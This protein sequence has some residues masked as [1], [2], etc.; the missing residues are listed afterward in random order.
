MDC[1]FEKPA[2]CAPLL[3]DV[4]RCLPIWIQR[5]RLTKQT[6]HRQPGHETSNRDQRPNHGR[7]SNFSIT[8]SVSFFSGISPL[9]KTYR[10]MRTESPPA[11]GTPEV[12]TCRLTTREP[13]VSR[14]PATVEKVTWPGC[15][16]NECVR[17]PPGT[18]NRTRFAGIK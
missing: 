16:W 11:G 7:Y 18:R 6:H 15:H 5:P 3:S 17:T 10:F 1:A 8:T 9:L 14:D 12:K 2:F 4:L 13:F